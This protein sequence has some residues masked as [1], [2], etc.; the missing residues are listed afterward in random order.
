M[1]YLMYIM[2]SSCRRRPWRPFWSSLLRLAFLVVCVLFILVHFLSISLHTYSASGVR[3]CPPE[4][5]SSYDSVPHLDL[6]SY[7]QGVKLDV[8]LPEGIRADQYVPCLQS[9]VTPNASNLEHVLQVIRKA[10]VLE[11]PFKSFVYFCGILPWQLA[12]RVREDFWPRDTLIADKRKLA[13]GYK[14]QHHRAKLGLE[15]LLQMR[16]AN[17]SALDRVEER[18]LSTWSTLHS[19]FFSEQFERALFQKLSINRKYKSRDFRVQRDEGGFEVGVH[20]DRQQKICTFQFYVPL[21]D[22]PE[23]AVV[24][25]GTNMHTVQQFKSRSKRTGMAPPSRKLL[26]LPNTA[27]AFK[28]HATSYHSVSTYGTDGGERLTFMINWYDDDQSGIPSRTWQ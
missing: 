2:E 13:L 26:F 9:I 11:K 19:L 20:P 18:R 25:Y 12:K 8:T 23:S 14:R 22:S 1:L 6:N 27:Y 15:K 10:T 7:K 16:S 4:I 17:T 5:C 28:V 24:K 3:G 21:T